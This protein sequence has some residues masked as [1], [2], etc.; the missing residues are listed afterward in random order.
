M[1]D[2][3]P[4]RPVALLLAAAL[5]LAPAAPAPAVP[6]GGVE[7]VDTDEADLRRALA[8]V[9]E[10]DVEAAA[11]LTRAVL[12]RAPDQAAGHEILGVILATQGDLAAAAAALERAVEIEPARAGAWTK[13]G[14]VRLAQGDPAGARGHFV[15]ALD[16]DPADRH[17]NQRMGLMLREEGDVTGAIAAFERGIA[18]TPPDYLGVKLDLALL[19]NLAGRPERTVELLAPFAAE[20]GADIAVHRTVANAE[21]TLER[22]DAAEAGYRAAL[23]IDPDDAQA[24]LGLGVALRGGGDTDG[25]LAAHEAALER[26]PGNTLVTLELARTR[27]AAG[28]TAAAVAGLEAALAEGPADPAPFETALAELHAA[29]G[30]ADRAA[31]I[32]AAQIEAGRGRPASYV[33]LGLLRQRAGDVAGAEAVWLAMAEAFPDSAEA[34]FRLGALY[35][36]LDRWPEAAARYEAGLERAPGSPELLRG[37]A[38]A[39]QMTGEGALAVGYAERLANRVDAEPAD[40]FLLGVLLQGEGREDAAADRYRRT[41]AAAPDHWPALNNL[42]V[43]LTEAGETD[44]ALRLAARATELAPEEAAATDTLGWAMFRAGDPAARGILARAVEQDPTGAIYRLHLARA[45]AA[46]GDVGAARTQAEAALA[47]DPEGPESA[48][49]RAFLDGL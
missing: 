6:I 7:E 41:L 10:G 42:A 32:W 36:A 22:F 30:D 25:A 3:S 13:L 45:E 20:P 29:S 33:N 9:R 1:P 35:G 5:V 15:H 28:E 43:I 47:L 2:P 16:L 14:D 11:A 23:A 8:L 4:L 34:D 19:Y 12:D 40:H 26:A 39:R 44:E 17:A 48:E 31:E 38:A 24:L 49:I 27:H 37:A 46:A 18:G 21:L